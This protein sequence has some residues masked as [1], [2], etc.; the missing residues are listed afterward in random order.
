MEE[1]IKQIQSGTWIWYEKAHEAMNTLNDL[2]NYPEINR[3][4][5]LLIVG[6]TNNGKSEIINRFAEQHA[7]Q[8]IKGRDYLYV[9]VLKIEAAGHWDTRSV[10]NTILTKLRVR[11]KYT[12]NLDEKLEQTAAALSNVG[13]KMLIIDEINQILATTPAKQR[14]VLS[15][16][17]T[18]N[19]RLKINI[20][21]AGT[22]PALRVINTEPDIANRFGTF[23]LDRWKMTQGYAEL[24][25]TLVKEFSA[26]GENAT[27]NKE[28][29]NYVLDESEGL[30]GE[31]VS[32]LKL[33]AVKAY[34]SG[35]EYITIEDIKGIQWT[36]P[37]N[38]RL[39][40]S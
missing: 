36:R 18:L 39:I 23:Y 15:T 9:P 12:G 5:N 2:L 38:R 35:K 3:A 11:H 24:L 28:M 21:G 7:P 19:N 1:K 40:V 20:V 16:L 27:V 29:A 25:L 32:I 33:A 37:S 26:N 22:K 34:S 6:D 17:K 31:I 30:L 14:A 8:F 10:F 4:P 13:C